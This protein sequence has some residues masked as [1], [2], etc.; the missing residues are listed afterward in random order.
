MIQKL[1]GLNINIKEMEAYFRDTRR[2]KPVFKLKIGDKNSYTG[3][4]I[5]KRLPVAGVGDSR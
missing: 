4:P 5:L 1:G 3:R 2:M